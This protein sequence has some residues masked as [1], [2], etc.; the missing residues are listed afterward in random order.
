MNLDEVFDIR[1]DY[2]RWLYGLVSEDETYRDDDDRYTKL[3]RQLHE[4]KFSEG[5]AY[6]IPNDGNRISDGLKLRREYSEEIGEDVGDILD[7]S[8][9]VLELLIG[10]ARRMDYNISVST[11]EDHTIDFFWELLENLGLDRFDDG[12]YCKDGTHARVDDI[13][14]VFCERMYCK[15]GQGGIFPLK[16]PPQDQVKTEIWY[17]MMAYLEENYPI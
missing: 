11:A 6:L 16:N 17:Q 10:I 12:R 9:S 8:C 15:D 2:F 4:R 13:I 7:R 1:H 5:T 14:T 3:L